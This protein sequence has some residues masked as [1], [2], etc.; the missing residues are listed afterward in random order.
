MSAIWVMFGSEIESCMR[1]TERLSVF[2][3]LAELGSIQDLED[4]PARMSTQGN[5]H[6]SCA[7]VPYVGLQLEYHR[8]LDALSSEGTLKYNLNGRIFESPASY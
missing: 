4:P 2:S 8:E 3:I 6:N 7:L 1:I 5:L